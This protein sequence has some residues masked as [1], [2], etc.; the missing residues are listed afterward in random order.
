M[1]EVMSHPST[2]FSRRSVIKATRL[3]SCVMSQMRQWTIKACKVLISVAFQCQSV[4]VCVCVCILLDL[5]TDKWL[6]SVTQLT[7]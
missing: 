5:N 4:C 2:T 6:W 1:D 7:S 3:M